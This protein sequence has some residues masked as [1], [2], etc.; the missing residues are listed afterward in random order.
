MQTLDKTH[1]FKIN[2]ICCDNCDPWIV[3]QFSPVNP[4][5]VCAATWP[6][7]YHCTVSQCVTISQD[8]YYITLQYTVTTQLGTMVVTV[9]H[10]K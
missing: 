5:Y 9:I 8:T 3:Q 2:E 10:K 6:S 4:S 7:T 1:I